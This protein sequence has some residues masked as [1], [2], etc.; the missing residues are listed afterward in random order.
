VSICSWYGQGDAS[1]INDDPCFLLDLTAAVNIGQVIGK[2]TIV[3]V[4][5]MKSCRGTEVCIVLF[6]LNLDAR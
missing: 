3:S 2:G 5:A 4:H 6:I 1:L